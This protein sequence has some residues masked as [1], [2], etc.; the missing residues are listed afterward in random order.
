MTRR[1][2]VTSND[3]DFDL[4]E[5]A[6]DSER[7][8]QDIVK[9]NPQLIPADD[10]GIDREL[11]VVGRETLLASGAIDLVC[12]SASGEVVLVEFKTG[13]KNP[14]FRH[15]LA[16]LIDYG[17]DLW[18]TTASD[19]D[20]GVV[21]RYLAGRECDT[22]AKGA[23]SLASLIERSGWNLSA[24][25]SAAMN[26][27]LQQVL[28]T[29]D[30]HFVVAAQRFTE[31]MNS[32]VDYLNAVSAKGRYHLVQVTRLEGKGL[33]AYSAQ[34]VAK[35]TK[36]TQS[37]GGSTAAQI[38]EAAF[39]QQ[40]ADVDYHDAL[41]DILASARKLGYKIAWYSRGA[42]LRI[43]TIDRPEP[44][45]IG[46]VFL[47]GAQWYGAR[48]VTL[49]V[50]PASLLVTPSVKVPVEAFVSEVRTIS[51]GV[52]GPPKLTAATFTPDVV[53]AAKEAIIQALDQLR[54]D[55]SAVE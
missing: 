15:A 49:G 1:V 31:P 38:T 23:S 8:L 28:T 25:E 33:A 53:P 46:W 42:S 29:G 55:L 16:Q 36:S 20:N 48:H 24:E 30:F 5:V 51:G 3:G 47:E 14:D 11:L 4:I 52:D 18:G 19:F 13:P 21:Q 7:Q 40:I 22:K 27:R 50:D 39:L 9:A 44:L 10:L 45:S 43:K 12:L 17:S 37:A 6:A 26:D 35:P 54:S 32:S 41:A 34:V 2:L